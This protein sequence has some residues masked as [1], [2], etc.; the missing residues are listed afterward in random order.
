MISQVKLLTDVSLLDEV[1]MVKHV[2]LKNHQYISG[3]ASGLAS[4]LKDPQV[5]LISLS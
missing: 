5:T 1:P 4:P 2:I 3:A